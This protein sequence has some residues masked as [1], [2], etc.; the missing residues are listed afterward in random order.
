VDAAEQRRVRLENWAAMAPGW[1]REREERQRV[2]APVTEWLVGELAPS[3]GD[4]VLEL[5]AGQGDVGFALAPRVGRLITSDFSAA[6]LDIARRRAEELGLTNVEFRELD[7]E[8]LEL[9]DQSVD[10][11]VCRWGYMLMPNPATALAETRRVLRPGGRL[12]FAVWASGDLNPWISLAGR[13]MVAHGHMPPPEPSEPGMFVLGNE[14][15]LRALVESA[16]LEDIKI[17]QVPV[18]TAYR[19]VDDYVRRSNEMG[20]M[21]AR[22]WSGA[23]DDERNAMTEEFRAAF[24]PFAAEGGYALPGLAVCVRAR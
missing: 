15:K 11:V 12:V 14:E 24:E 1:E 16:G 13:I 23:G 10:G 9:E 17:D 3:P 6:M 21:F 19:D 2:A 20:G 7:A 22:A 5:A 18:Q 8:A 4:V